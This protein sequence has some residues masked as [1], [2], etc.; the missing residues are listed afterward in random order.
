[1]CLLVLLGTFAP[2]LAV[3]AL[4]LFT[5]LMNRAFDT[6]IFPLLGVIFLPYTT[7][8]YALAVGPLGPTNAWGWFAVFMGLLL[9]LSS[10]GQAYNSRNQVRWPVTT[11]RA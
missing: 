3:L 1:M 2:R 4:W 9:D 11:A 5:P 10:A 6:W 8:F 7:L